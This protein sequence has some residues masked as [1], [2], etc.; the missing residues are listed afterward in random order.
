[1]ATVF[2]PPPKALPEPAQRAVEAVKT[3]CGADLVPA[4]ARVLS[5]P[6]PAGE[7]LRRGIRRAIVDRALAPAQ[8]ER[9]ATAVRAVRACQYGT[10]S[11][12]AAGRHAGHTDDPIGYEGALVTGAVSALNTLAGALPGAPE[13]AAVPPEARRSA[14]FFGLEE[15]PWP[16][17]ALAGS[18]AILSARWD[19]MEGALSPGALDRP[20]KAVGAYA[21]SLAQRSPF[22]VPFYGGG[23]RRLGWDREARQE[24]GQVGPLIPLADFLLL[25]PDLGAEHPSPWAGRIQG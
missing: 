6:A 18:P 21:V 22:G 23:A 17:W 12:T 2:V 8:K 1:M 19:F 14:R 4:M 5:H 25:E 11:R 16:L 13:P 24:T 15:A 9:V 7:D 3:W 20:T 10:R